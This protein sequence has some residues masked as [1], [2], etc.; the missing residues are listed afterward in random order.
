MNWLF[1][2]RYVVKCP[3]GTKK[4]VFRNPEDAF[5]ILATAKMKEGKLTGSGSGESVIA[6]AIEGKSSSELDRL[7]LQLEKSIQFYI[8][9]LIGAYSNY[10]NDPCAYAEEYRRSVDTATANLLRIQHAQQSIA[11]IVDLTREG[12]IPSAEATE[13]AREVMAKINPEYIAQETNAAIALSLQEMV[14]WKERGSA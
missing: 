11:G 8:A 10:T 3:D 12:K 7:F 13:F 9:Q 4:Y 6:A 2:K 5:P 1:G 14:D